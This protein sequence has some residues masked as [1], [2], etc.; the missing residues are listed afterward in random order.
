GWRGGEAPRPAYTGIPASTPTRILLV[1]R[2]GAVQSSVRAGRPTIRAAEP[3]YPALLVLNKILGGGTDSRLFAILREQKGWTYGAWTDVDRPR[4]VGRL[5]AGM[6]VR[7]EVT[8]S[9]VAE[10]LVQLRR[11]ATHPV[12]AEEL[13]AAKGYLVGSFPIGIQT[14]DDVAA[15]VAL[16]RLKGL[17]IED[18]LQR[19]ERISAVT[20]DDVRRVAARYLRPDSL[21]VTV[22]GDAGRVLAGLEGI[23]PVELMDAEGRPM[24]R[25]AL[26]VRA[27][28]E[29]FDISRLRPYTAEYEI[30]AGGNPIGRMSTTLAREGDGWKHSM[31]GSF[32]PVQQ[33]IT[34][35]WGPDWEPRTYEETYAGAFEGRAQVRVEN[36]RFVGTGQMPPQAG[37]NKTFDAEAVAGSAF[38]Q[39]D[40]AML[41]VADLAEGKTIVIPVFNTS[42]GAVAPVTFAVGVAESVTVPAGTFQAFRVSS[43]GGSAAMT[44]WLRA[45]APHVVLKQELVG[46]PVVVQLQSIQ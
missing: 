28:D 1:H 35:V 14:A 37:G 15:Q 10:M 12:T 9:A 22:V 42:T 41:S 5:M 2:P 26:Q 25:S 23:A 44:L 33:T 40:E 17:P 27:S 21:V 43:T 20:V 18:L 4:D 7:S 11:I 34:G 13:E 31:S 32:G 6:D 24:D 39:M 30:L 29:S 8:D 36:G 19:R 3:D 16:T 45:D 38:S 46:Q